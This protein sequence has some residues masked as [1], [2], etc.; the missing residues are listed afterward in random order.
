MTETEIEIEIRIGTDIID[1]IAAVHALHPRTTGMKNA[2][3]TTTVIER[4]IVGGTTETTREGEI[5]T[6]PGKSAGGP[7]LM[8]GD[9][10]LDGARQVTAKRPAISF[11]RRCLASR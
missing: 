6:V 10:R 2:T 4:T 8:K 7:G 1:A 3:E 9:N 11:L 5:E